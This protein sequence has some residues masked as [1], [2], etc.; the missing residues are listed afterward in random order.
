VRELISSSPDPVHAL[1]IDAEAVS[2]TD[3]DGADVLTELATELRRRGITVAL[4]R[5]ESSVQ[6][7]WRRA[8][9]I[10]AIDGE[11]QL[12]PT[13]IEAVEAVR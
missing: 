13:V 10:D 5:V 8:G 2:Q 4:A 1:V 6:E 9:T 7:L 3:T 11:G 12:F